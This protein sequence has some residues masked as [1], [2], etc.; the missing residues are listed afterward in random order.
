MSGI[1]RVN[2][3][4]DYFQA[5]NVP[6]NDE[7][8]SWEARGVIGYLL[9]KPDGWQC[10]NEDLV[11]KGPAGGHKVARVL[12]ELKRYGYMRRYRYQDAKGL[13]QWVT[14]I[15]ET[16][17]MNPDYTETLELSIPQLS[18]DGLSTNGSSIDGKPPD[19]VNTEEEKT[20]KQ[21]AA[22]AASLPPDPQN[23]VDDTALGEVDF[24]SLLPHQGNGQTKD[25]N[26]A[27]GQSTGGAALGI[28]SGRFVQAIG[29]LSPPEIEAAQTRLDRSGWNIKNAA[30]Y[31]A[32]VYFLAVTGWAAPGESLRSKWLNRKTGIP[33]QLVE[34]GER[35]LPRFYRLAWERLKASKDKG[36][37][38]SISWPGAFTGTMAA[39]K[40]EGRAEEATI[41]TTDGGVY[42]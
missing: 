9:S 5:S 36:W 24:E 6:F 34:F 28:L 11:A 41:A 35:D 40:N 14:D 22:D 15:Y 29:G 26:P 23:E 37:Q 42:L 31:R 17:E 27:I 12:D 4:K 1:V 30:F 19:I 39:L 33:A 7:R 13:F 8:L 32:V 10:R 2:K 20:N 38:G 25:P 18:I 21:H 16:P 3:D